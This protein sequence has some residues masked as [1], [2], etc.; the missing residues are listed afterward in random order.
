MDNY[1]ADGLFELFKSSMEVEPED[2]SVEGAAKRSGIVPFNAVEE[3]KK[4]IADLGK[5]PAPDFFEVEDIISRERIQRAINEPISPGGVFNAA[6]G[7]PLIKAA[8]PAPGDELMKLLETETEAEPF[9]RLES[10][11]DDRI[12]IQPMHKAAG[13]DEPPSVLDEPLPEILAKVAQ[14]MSTGPARSFAEKLASMGS[15]L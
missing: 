12:R 4:R 14:R 8:E 3:C 6:T 13:G 7:Q 10:V 15:G 2:Q 9:D 11:P 5:S 1:E